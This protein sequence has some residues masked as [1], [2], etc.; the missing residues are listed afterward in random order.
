MRA[1][2]E[3]LV[4]P[5]QFFRQRIVPGEQASGLGFAVA[6]VAV[7]EASRLVLVPDAVPPV[8]GGPVISAVLA[9]GLATLLVTPVALHL[10]AALQTLLLRPVV[11]DRAGV[12][13]TVQVVA[14]AAAPCAL[15]GI[16]VPGL[17][18]ACAVYGTVLLVLGL[19]T[20]HRTTLLRAALAGAVPSALVFG[21]GFRGFGAL[22]DLLGRAV[23]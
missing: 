23:G 15:A 10:V 14:Y 7:E 9:V 13:T 5:R 17:R 4:R 2:L 21:Y 1:W 20:V 18:V 19:A 8:A 12:S 16:P 3:V 11:H 22:I 6:V